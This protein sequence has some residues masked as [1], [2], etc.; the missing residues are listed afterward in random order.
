MS[1]KLMPFMFSMYFIGIRYVVYSF[2]LSSYSN[3]LTFQ[4]EQP[5]PEF[6]D[7][8]ESSTK[9][10]IAYVVTLLI[11]VALIL[12]AIS[13]A[14]FPKIGIMVYTFIC[15]IF[16]L[17]VYVLYKLLSGKFSSQEGQFCLT[18][19]DLSMVYCTCNKER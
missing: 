18:D 14:N 4:R 13:S 16:C 8:C 2:Y 12:V 11:G 9:R 1:H 17:L 19:M 3:V 10:N 5:S 7:L 15:S 6:L